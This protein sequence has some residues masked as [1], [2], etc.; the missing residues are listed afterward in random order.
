MLLIVALVLVAAF[1]AVTA[2][3]RYQQRQLSAMQDA[4]LRIGRESPSTDVRQ[5]ES[6]PAPV[7]RYL[8]LALPEPPAMR[9][10]R[11]RQR[12]TLRMDPHSAR[13]MTFEAEHLAIPHAIGFLWNAR[14]IAPLLHV[15]VRDAFI[16]G[17]GSGQV[18]LLS[19]FTV[20]A[21]AE[22][23]EMN[24]GALYRFLAEA[25]WYPPALVPSQRLRWT[26]PH[27]AGD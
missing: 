16:D 27:R 3:W 18:S 25:V 8:R 9:I 15:R 20:S 19:A 1:I 6:L 7:A 2:G 22:T 26:H 10:V 12:G 13:W 5:L 11:L 4:L 21:A 17:L 14:D 24:S 23:P